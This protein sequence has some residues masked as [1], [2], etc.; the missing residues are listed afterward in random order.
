MVAIKRSGVKSEEKKTGFESYDG[1]EPSRP[2]MYRAR[3]VSNKYK[4]FK[5]NAEGVQNEGLVVSVV[6]EAQKGDPKKHAQFDGW[7]TTTNLVFGDKEMM[8]AR[9]SNYYAALGVKDEPNIDIVSNKA[10]ALEAGT[11]VNK[12]GGKDPV[13]LYVNVDLKPDTYNGVQRLAVDGIY[14]FRDSVKFETS[15]DA[16]DDEDDEDLLDDEDGEEGD[17]EYD[18]RAEE[19]AGETLASLRST[20]KELEITTTGLKKDGL[21][22][23]ILAAEFEEVDD[24]EED[25]EAEEEDA[26][27]EEEDDEYDEET[28]REELADL[29]RV[30]LKKILRDLDSSFTVL[31]KHSDDDLRDAIVS[32]EQDETPF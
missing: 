8:L 21:I 29:D 3:I 9:E 18:A 4:R 5:A 23:A 12:I 11:K 17:E 14:K 28:R 15:D 22:E 19:L 6:L 2:G 27:E 30:E 1:P 16:D 25:D 26:D 13:G 32:K 20:A 7:P 24:E 31:K 10:D